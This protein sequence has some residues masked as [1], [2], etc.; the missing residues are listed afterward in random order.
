TT[1][2]RIVELGVPVQI[3]PPA[4]WRVAKSYCNPDGRRRLGPLGWTQQMHTGLGWR[5][6]AL[7]SIALDAAGH[8]VFPVFPAALSDRHDMVEGELA[9]REGIATV[10]AAVIVAGVDVRARERHVIEAPLDFDVP[11]QANDRRQFEADGYGADLPVVH[12]D[13]L[14]LPL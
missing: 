8:D 12:R 11:E 3:I 1:A 7:A 9:R 13:H 5:T 14:D 10:L 4:L 6:P 2:L